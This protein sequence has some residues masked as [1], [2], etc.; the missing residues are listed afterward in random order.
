MTAEIRMRIDG[1]AVTAHIDERRL[2]AETLR[3]DFDARAPKIGCATGDCG[4]C[5]VLLGDQP[6]KSCLELAACHD[7]SEITTLEGLAGSVSDALRERFVAESA[8]QCG[9]CLSGMLLVSADL[10][11]GNPR[12]TRDEVRRALAG[13]LCRCTG[14]D[15]IVTAVVAA[16]AHLT[17]QAG[18]D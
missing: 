8:F 7:G 1:R 2:L 14:Y 12:P 17:A 6:I 10:L 15:R 4:A 18:Q 16:A 3:E 11:S 5:T 13:N 9:Y